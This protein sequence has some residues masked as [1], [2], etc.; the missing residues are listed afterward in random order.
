MSAI[1]STGTTNA[2]P[3]VAK[4]V[5]RDTTD[6]A[7]K[8]PG[9]FGR[10]F[11]SLGWRHLVGVTALVVA[12]FPV[13]CGKGERSYARV[14]GLEWDGYAERWL[15]VSAVLF[16]ASGALYLVRARPGSSS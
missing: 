9:G 13:I 15:I 6:R 4:A 16:L 11:T 1:D 3:A 7:A 2:A 10:W 8:P 14:S 5:G 12:F